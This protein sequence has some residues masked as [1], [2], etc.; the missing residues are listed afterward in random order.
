MVL[1]LKKFTSCKAF[2]LAFLLCGCTQLERDNIY[3]PD[4]VNYNPSGIQNYCVYSSTEQCF[5]GFYSSCPGGGVMSDT[6]PYSSSSSENISGGESSSS[7]FLSSSSSEEEI[8]SSSEEDSSSSSEEDSSSSSEEDSSSS[9]EEDSSSS[10]SE[11][12][13]TDFAEGTEREHYGKNKKQFCDERDGNK[14]VYVEI[15]WQI[16]MAENLNYD[17][18]NSKCYDSDPANCTKYGRLYDWPTAWTACPDGWHFPSDDEWTELTAYVEQNSD[19]SSCAATKL[20]AASDWNQW[21]FGSGTDDY[22]FSALPG[23]TGTWNGSFYGVGDYGT[24]WSASEYGGNSAY[25]RDMYYDDENIYWYGHDK[26]NLFSIRC[27]RGQNL[28]SLD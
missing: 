25:N 21:E 18:S 9:F 17:A 22:G 6:C 14:Y 10:S 26:S 1:G 20:K 19:C 5:S 8:S 23:G 27:V 28:D 3:D 11:D 16:W 15:G 24:W 7:V 13:C 4:G 2:C 12:L